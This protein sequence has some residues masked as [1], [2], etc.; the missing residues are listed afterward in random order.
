MLRV[1][2]RAHAHTAGGEAF[3]FNGFRWFWRH[4]V[5]NVPEVEDVKA[6]PERLPSEAYPSDHMSLVAD[7]LVP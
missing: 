5:L 7:L 3:A 1:V 6:F 2:L 4:Q